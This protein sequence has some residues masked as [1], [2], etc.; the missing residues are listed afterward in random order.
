[1]K[2]LV[3]WELRRFFSKKYILIMALLLIALNVYIIYYEYD[4]YLNYA[5]LQENINETLVNIEGDITSEKTQS[6]E[7]KHQETLQLLKLDYESE[8]AHSN[9]N[10]HRSF[11][12]KY[13]DYINDTPFPME[14][15]GEVYES[16]QEVIEAL[17]KY[18]KDSP[19]YFALNKYLSLVEKSNKENFYVMHWWEIFQQNSLLFLMVV[20]IIAMATVFGEDYSGNGVYLTLSSKYGKTKLV[21]ARIIAGA[22]FAFFI[23]LAFYIVELINRLWLHGINGYQG[24]VSINGCIYLPNETPLTIF[25]LLDVFTMISSI[26]LA[27]FTMA[28]SLFTKRTILTMITMV[29][30]IFGAEMIKIPFISNLSLRDIINNFTNS[31]IYYEPI[32][33]GKYVLHEP[34]YL[35]IS[36]LL[37]T[38]LS[39]IT[40]LYKG[41]RQ[42][43]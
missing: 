19:T 31:F 4:E 17:K 8:E 12:V 40:I 26:C 20:I 29:I 16:K 5:Y 21:K 1:M 3:N 43:L 41:K 28:V 42:Q 15:S 23:F 36:L 9:V 34:L 32:L 24:N 33:V 22:T 10:L 25:A 37:I 14:Y 18:K 6:I 30:I 38:T 35:F 27:F 7:E 13:L 2:Q 39:L 11:Y